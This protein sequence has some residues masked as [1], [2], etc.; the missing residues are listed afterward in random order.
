MYNM[1]IKNSEIDIVVLW[2]DSEDAKWRTEFEL[3]SSKL[4]DGDKDNIRFRDYNLIKYWF[5]GIEKFCPWARKVHFVTSGHYPNW[6]NLNNKR[7]NFVKHSDYIPSEFLPT[8]NSHVIELNLHRIKEL[9]E[10]FV[11]FNDDFF[12]IDHISDEHFFSGDIP[13]DCAIFSPIV[14]GGLSHI[15]IN[16]VEIINKYYHKSNVIKKDFWKWYSP[17][18]GLN[19]L[20]TICLTPWPHFVGFKDTHLPVSFKKSTF[21]ELWEKEPEIM[22]KTCFSK[23]RS[24][25]DVSQYLVRYWQ[26]VKGVFNPKNTMKYASYNVLSN[27][28]LYEIKKVIEKQKKQ[29]IIINDG[30][31]IDFNYAKLELEKSFEL[32]LPEKSSFEN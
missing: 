4:I 6:L 23:F 3:Y 2:V 10:N 24:N 20:R 19:L 25:Q 26:L 17:K 31:D 11:Y 16:N 32:I 7:L 9:S 1:N 29:I 12:V 8:F 21:V 28:S 5:R 18:Y 15:L 27:S 13:N 22:E 30:D 14:P